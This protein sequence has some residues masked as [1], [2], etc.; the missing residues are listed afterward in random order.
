MP[1]VLVLK[2][3][4]MNGLEFEFV[5]SVCNQITADKMTN[6][7]SRRI[8]CFVDC[9]TQLKMTSVR[10]K[11]VRDQT[12]CGHKCS[13]E[14][15]VFKK[16]DNSYWSEQKIIQTKTDFNFGQSVKGVG[17][18]IE[19]AHRIPLKNQNWNVLWM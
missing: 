17:E 13:V 14:K 7:K 12:I 9:W 4:S 5:Q 15:N 2:S 11:S 18:K 19:C 3:M 1:N 8:V 6:E 16:L 10:V